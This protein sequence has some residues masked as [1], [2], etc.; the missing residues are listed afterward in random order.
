MLRGVCTRRQ[1]PLQ[2]PHYFELKTKKY[3]KNPFQ[4]KYCCSTPTELADQNGG[5]QL[6]GGRRQSGKRRSSAGIAHNRSLHIGQR[7]EILRQRHCRRNILRRST[8]AIALQSRTL[9]G[10]ASVRAKHSRYCNFIE[11]LISTASVYT[12]DSAESRAAIGTRHQFTVVEHATLGQAFAARNST[13]RRLS[14]ANQR[15]SPT[16]AD[17]STNDE[18][19][20]SKL[21]FI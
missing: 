13:C 11:T 14:Q 9:H 3:S 5:I 17:Q 12:R 4:Q 10:Q 15:N 2:G 20:Y 18:V 7:T 16:P 8:V 6:A 1:S 19:A 21:L